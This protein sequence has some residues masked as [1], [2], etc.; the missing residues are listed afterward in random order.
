MAR[1]RK[2]VQNYIIE[3]IDQV[4]P[5]SKNADMYRNIFSVMSDEDFDDLMVDIRAGKRHLY[6]IEPNWSDNPIDLRN[7]IELGKKLGYNFMQSL[8]IEGEGDQPDSL[9]PEK[10]LILRLPAK[11]ASQ[12]LIK[13]I[14]VPKHNKSIDSLTGQPT[15][16][17]KGAKLSYPELQICAAMQLDNC[18]IEMAKYNGGDIK[19]RFAYTA[20]L[21]K[22][23]KVNLDSLKPYAS[24][25]VSTKT[26]KTFFT[27]A[28]LKNNL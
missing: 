22:Y 27:C 3:M 23:G 15:G 4:V 17:S 14:S 19:G 11:R 28:H 5:G 2:K 8:W 6:V 10:A 1:N 26:L 13:K 21:S 25:V 18:M 12:L 20:M 9:T 16:E 7:N 24:G